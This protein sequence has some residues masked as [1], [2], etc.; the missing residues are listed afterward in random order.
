M[1]VA[2][3]STASSIKSPTNRQSVQKA[4]KSLQDRLKLYNKCKFF[5]NSFFEHFKSLSTSKNSTTQWISHV[6][7][8]CFRLFR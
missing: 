5:V 6:L 2:E 3:M 1:L 8:S 4:L 7:W